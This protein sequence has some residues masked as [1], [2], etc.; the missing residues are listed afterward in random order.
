MILF[1]MLVPRSGFC[2]KYFGM[3]IYISCKDLVLFDLEENCFTC[4]DITLLTT[5]Q[6]DIELVGT[7]VLLLMILQLSQNYS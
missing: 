2:I 1:N 7:S 6:I 5:L 4:I 3:I